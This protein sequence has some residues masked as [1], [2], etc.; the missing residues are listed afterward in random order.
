MNR[1][2]LY[3]SLGEAKDI[4]EN[5]VNIHCNSC[6]RVLMTHPVEVRLTESD[7]ET[8]KLAHAIRWRYERCNPERDI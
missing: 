3:F 2:D 7:L 5:M 8:V 6:G 4:G 1:V